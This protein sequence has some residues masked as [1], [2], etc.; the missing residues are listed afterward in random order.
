MRNTV[1]PLLALLLAAAACGKEEKK[2]GEKS[3]TP[4]V[5]NDGRSI[6]LTD[7]ASLA[8]FKT[9]TVA[10]ADLSADLAAPAQV[11][12][13]SVGNRLVLFSNPDLSANYTE[14][15][16]AAAGIAQQE[17]VV[18]QRQAAIEQ[19][20]AVVRQRQVEIERFQ[21]LLAHGSGTG[22]ELADARVDKLAAETERNNAA[23]EKA[24]A[25]AELLARRSLA[26]EHRS[27][28]RMAGFDP[29]ALLNARPGMAWVVAD[30]PENLVAQIKKGGSCRLVFTAYPSDTLTGIIEDI[31]DVVD[32][33]TRMVRLRIAV[34]NADNRLK[35]GMFANLS[36]GVREGR[37]IS[38]AKRA[39]VTVQGKHFVFVK[40]AAGAF[41]RRE[42]QAGRQIGDRMVVFG[43][44][45]H[46]DAVVVEGVMQLKG[47]SF[48]Y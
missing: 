32:V 27:K 14:L 44:L 25:E 23:A 19:L 45:E 48:G 29:D 8:F 26:L 35:A 13:T 5:S 6:A 40:T 16:N 31:A 34:P 36:L 21:D 1:I 2:A 43:G 15:L 24:V 39:L 18:R 12:A 42:V 17:A 10:S 37:F 11:A 7:P 4:V 28:L 46:G 41:E 47:L 3:L 30:I 22:K 38:V 20:E 9:E 33:S